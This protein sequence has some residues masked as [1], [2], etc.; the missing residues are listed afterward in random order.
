MW[1]LVAHFVF[2]VDERE[3]NSLVVAD[4]LPTSLPNSTVLLLAFLFLLCVCPRV[5][6]LFQN[7]HGSPW[8]QN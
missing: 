6:S 4:K 3:R 1:F 7:V 5:S 8:S 2:I